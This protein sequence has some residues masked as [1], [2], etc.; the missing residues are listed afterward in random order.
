MLTENLIPEHRPGVGKTRLV[1]KLRNV[2]PSAR[3]SKSYRNRGLEIP[4]QTASSRD[5]QPGNFAPPVNS[6]RAVVIV[7]DAGA[8]TAR[9]G[10]ATR[11]DQL[12]DEVAAVAP[13]CVTHRP[14]SATNSGAVR[15]R[16][17]RCPLGGW[18]PARAQAV[19]AGSGWSGCSAVCVADVGARGAACAASPDQ[20]GVIR[21]GPL[22]RS[23]RGSEFSPTSSTMV[24]HG[25]PAD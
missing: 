22:V 4:A 12:I 2:A 13:A 19:G 17:G 8:H 24:H 21:H 7:G 10:D 3:T 11:I 18:C 15:R 1:R 14:T 9:N 20:V 16:K 25:V 5:G 23:N 6:P